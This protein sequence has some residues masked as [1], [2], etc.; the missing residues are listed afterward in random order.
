MSLRT[1]LQRRRRRLRGERRGAATVEFAVVAPL[2]F[3]LVTAVIEFGRVF[4]VVGLLTY[5][6]QQGARTGALDNSTTDSATAAVTNY[7]SS[8]GISGATVT[9]SPDPPSSAASG[10]NV[11][12]TAS[13]PFT[14]VSWLP[15]PWFLRN[16]ILSATATVR[17]ETGQ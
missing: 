3:L 9:V 12:V 8:G 16:T 5:A 1:L 15:S 11:T 14:R 13:I 10:Q 7:L 2:F 4:M 6:A 17:R